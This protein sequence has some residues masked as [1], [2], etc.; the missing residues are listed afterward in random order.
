MKLE[1]KATDEITYKNTY[2]FIFLP[3]I[4]SRDFLRNCLYHFEEGV[5]T[6][7]TLT[8]LLKYVYMCIYEEKIPRHP[9]KSTKIEFS[10]SFWETLVSFGR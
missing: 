9:T 2:C 10:S 4:K 6:G 7:S 8:N 5:F 3:F 1:P